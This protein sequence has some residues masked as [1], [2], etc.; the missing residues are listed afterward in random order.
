MSIPQDGLSIPQDGRGVEDT[1]TAAAGDPTMSRRIKSVIGGSIGNLVE[2]Y[3]WYVYSAA[4][5]YFA[6]IFFPQGDRTAQLLSAA[7]IFSVGFLVRPI[8]S[9]LMGIYADRRGRLSAMVVSMGVMGVASFA[10]ALTPGYDTIGVF[11]PILLV[12]A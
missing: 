7:A 1:S 10:I 8:G 2:W 11:A 5:L 6:P 12:V 4:A 3:D 9:W